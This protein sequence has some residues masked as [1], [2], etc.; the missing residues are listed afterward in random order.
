MIQ[1]DILNKKLFILLQVMASLTQFPKP[2]FM[3]H[4]YQSRI[5]EEPPSPKIN[6]NMPE[7]EMPTLPKTLDASQLNI[8]V[9]MM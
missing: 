4:F 1:N 3:D 8:Q 6:Y 9:M 5:K 2:Q 7:K